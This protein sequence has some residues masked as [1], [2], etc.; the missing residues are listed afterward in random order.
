MVDEE[1]SAQNYKDKGSTEEETAS[2]KLMR[3]NKGATTKSLVL[4]DGGFWACLPSPGLRIECV[5]PPSPPL[6]SAPFSGAGKEKGRLGS[7][8]EQTLL[9]RLH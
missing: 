1:Y 4:D 9:S 7:E 8:L 6:P 2:G 3:S 5:T